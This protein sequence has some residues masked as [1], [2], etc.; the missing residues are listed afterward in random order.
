MRPRNRI[1]THPGEILLDEFLEPL[2]IT[3][4]RLAAH[5]KIPLQRVNEIVKAK[6]GITTETAWFLAQTFDTTP[7]F[8]LNLQRDYDLAT[9]QPTRQVPRWSAQA[10][11]SQSRD[12]FRKKR[13]RRRAS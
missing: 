13:G 3:Q 2:H 5:L 4:V 6:R 10:R 7:E 1:P 9:N 8:W 12:A 11:E